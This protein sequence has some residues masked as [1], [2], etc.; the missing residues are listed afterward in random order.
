VPRRAQHRP[1][2]SGR[3]FHAAHPRR[4]RAHGLSGEMSERELRGLTASGGVA[5]GRALVWLDEEPAAAGEG[6]PLAALD[7][8]AAELARGAERFRAAGLQDEAE[9][10]ETNKLM[11]ED[12]ALRSEV[13]RLGGE[14][15]SADALRQATARHADLLAT[16]PDPLLAARATDI[17]QLGVRAV[18]ALGGA[19]MPAVT[20]ASILI[21]RD[22]GPVDIR[23]EERRVG[24]EGRYGL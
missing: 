7:T 9:I 17:R 24:K 12:P 8:V 20:E 5:I 21:A 23:S 6:D 15:G 3:H 11:V 1:P 18:R 14:L 10:L 2:G 22:L 19:A 16:I 4:S 13:E